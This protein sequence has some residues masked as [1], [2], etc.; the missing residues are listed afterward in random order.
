MEY[1]EGIYFPD[2]KCWQKDMFSKLSTG[3]F[4][5]KAQNDCNADSSKD[6]M[7]CGEFLYR[8]SSD[9]AW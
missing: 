5:W 7:E 4:S 8:E 3:S 9:W 2:T 6:I 1:N